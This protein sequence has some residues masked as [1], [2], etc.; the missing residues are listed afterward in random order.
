MKNKKILCVECTCDNT[1]ISIIDFNKV[2]YFSKNFNQNDLLTIYGGVMPK[3]TAYRHSYNFVKIKDELLN[4]NLLDDID[5]IGCSYGP[6]ILFSILQGI[7]FILGVS[8]QIKKPLYAINHIEAH[9]LSPRLEFDGIE[10]PFINLV[11]SGGHC[12]LVKIVS[13]NNYVLLGESM[14]IAPGNFLDK[15]AR[16]LDL[17]CPNGAYIE[18]QALNYEIENLSYKNFSHN[19]S[20]GFSFTGLFTQF[21]KI[22]ETKSHGVKVLCTSIQSVLAHYLAHKTK[23]ILMH[24]KDNI[25]DCNIL[26]LSGGV[27]CNKKVDNVFKRIFSTTD[28]NFK[29]KSVSKFAG[30]NAEMIGWCLKEKLN[31]LTNKEKSI[32]INDSF[33]KLPKDFF[34]SIV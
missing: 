4:S 12:L 16:L 5:Y 19:K 2:V 32:N 28:M 27:S 8:L 11:I 31:N 33:N 34:S 6:G 29:I 15:L 3:Y 14:D 30:D 18:K 21:K 25:K 10:Y 17:E 22:I 20:L 7:A 23:Q 13:L 9:L 26:S 1:A 24:H